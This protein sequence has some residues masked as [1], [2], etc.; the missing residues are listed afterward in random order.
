MEIT[1]STCNRL[2]IHD[3]T[4]SSTWVATLTTLTSLVAEDYVLAILLRAGKTEGMKLHTKIVCVIFTDTKVHMLMM[5]QCSILC[6]KY[7]ERS[8]MKMYCEWITQIEISHYRN[9]K[10]IMLQDSNWTLGNRVVSL[11]V[12]EYEMI[13]ISTCSANKENMTG[14]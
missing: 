3:I 5:Q 1:I 2:E 9:D 7:T 10:A 11:A 4:S 8:S 14:G 12:T 6:I 13:M